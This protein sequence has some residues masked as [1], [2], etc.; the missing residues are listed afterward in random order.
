MKT[1]VR[2]KRE[3]ESEIQSDERVLDQTVKMK[4]RYGAVDDEE[5]TICEPLFE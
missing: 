3:N 4:V 5:L 2:S 1:K